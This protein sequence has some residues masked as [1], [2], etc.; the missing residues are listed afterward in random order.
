[1]LLTASACRPEAPRF[2]TGDLIFQCGEGAMSGA[3]EAAT[4]RDR[5]V[6]FSHVGI[7]LAGQP[8]DSV[9]EA[10]SEGGVRITAIADFLARSARREGRPAAV[11]MRLCDTTGVAASVARARTRRGASYDYSFRPDNGR[12]YCSELVCEHY[13]RPDDKPI[14]AAQ[15][16]N[17]RAP[18]GTMPA[19]WVELFDRLGEPIPEGVPGTNPNDLSHN[20]ELYELFRWF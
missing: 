14:F 19:Y 10:T 9:L 13:L 11:V 6:S 4:S 16:M 2:Q 17:F 12:Y 15:P 1:M 18:D 5:E 20:E 3:I 8:T 7:I